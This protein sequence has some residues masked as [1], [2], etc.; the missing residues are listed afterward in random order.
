MSGIVITKR[1]VTENGKPFKK[2]RLGWKK[3]IKPENNKL[4]IMAKYDQLGSCLPNIKKST[5]VTIFFWFLKPT[6]KQ[7]NQKTVK[8]DINV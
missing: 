2:I 8:K 1:D 3:N 7:K 4:V 5:G 6:Y